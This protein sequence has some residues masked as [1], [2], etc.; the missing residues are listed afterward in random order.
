MML[1]VLVCGTVITFLGN[2]HFLSIQ[3]DWKYYTIILDTTTAQ[4]ESYSLEIYISSFHHTFIYRP[5]D[6]NSFSTYYKGSWFCIWYKISFSWSCYILSL[7]YLGN[8]GRK[9]IF[10][11]KMKTCIHNSQATKLNIFYLNFFKRKRTPCIFIAE[12][13]KTVKDPNASL[14]KFNPDLTKGGGEG[15]LTIANYFVTA[16]SYGH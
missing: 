16:S 13:S 8:F 11:D 5:Q 7:D 6:L 4:F 3:F 15:K 1:Y 2:D 12:Y 10:M 9:N 14:T